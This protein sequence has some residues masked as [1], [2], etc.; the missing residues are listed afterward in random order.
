MNHV[1]LRC[2]ILPRVFI[3]SIFNAGF[4][5]ITFNLLKKVFTLSSMP[6]ILK[7]IQ[8]IRKQAVIKKLRMSC[9]KLSSLCQ[10]IEPQFA[11][12]NLFRTLVVLS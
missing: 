6:K 4:E 11:W 7:L 5:V 12:I 9:L 2:L 1:G 10:K 8:L 3:R